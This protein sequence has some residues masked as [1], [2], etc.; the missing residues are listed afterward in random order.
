M[1]QQELFDNNKGL[2]YKCVNDLGVRY[3]Q[4]EDAIQEGMVALWLAGKG[5]DQTRGVKFSSYAYKYIYNYIKKQMRKNL[6]IK[7]NKE[8]YQLQ[9]E[10]YG[11][12]ET[13]GINFNE[14]VDKVFENK[15]PA[16]KNKFLSVQAG[17]LEFDETYYVINQDNIIINR[18]DY[19]KALLKLKE[20]HYKVWYIIHE[21]YILN[22]PQGAISKE[23]N[24]GRIRF[25][26]L[27]DFGLKTLKKELIYAEK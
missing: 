21:H 10:I 13:Q 7:P 15:S 25:K 26:K 11:L 23:L 8:F 9:G 2:V 3:A 17:V 12:I 20:E 22:R 14:A 19:E 24:I 27:L 5:Y 6:S 16:E 1:K 18:L 4:K